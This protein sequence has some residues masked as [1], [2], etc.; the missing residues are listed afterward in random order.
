MYIFLLRSNIYSNNK[1]FKFLINSRLINGEFDQGGVI[2]ARR[3]T[4]LRAFQMFYKIQ[5]F[6]F[7][8]IVIIKKGEIVKSSTS[9]IVF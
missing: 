9:N 6:I 4:C 2:N 5:E 3:G 7:L 8:M 1:V